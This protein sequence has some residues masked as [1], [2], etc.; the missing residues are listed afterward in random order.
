[1]AVPE[2]RQGAARWFGYMLDWLYPSA[3]AVCEEVQSGG[4]TLCAACDAD[5]PR[6]APPFC[7]RCGEHFE[8]RIDDEFTCPNCSTLRF[9]FEFARPAMMLDERTRGMIHR[10][11]YGRQLYLA[12]DLAGLA[13]GAFEDERFASSIAGKWPLVPVPLHRSRLRERH[14]NQ[15]E[16]IARALSH[17]TGLP[18]VRALRRVRSTGHQTSL[19]R[20]QRLEN[21]RGAF[22]ITRAGRAAAASSPGAIL[23]DDVFTTGAT[24]N[25]CARELR[26]AG[27]KEVRVVTVMRG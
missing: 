22:A 12:K 11:K 21:L 26:R 20:S 25:E 2:L 18:M 10:L 8:G 6:L 1:M 5:L 14:F 23:V 4:R 15:A 7:S 9:A 3:C 16:E 13:A 17:Q 27:F 24:V 19:T